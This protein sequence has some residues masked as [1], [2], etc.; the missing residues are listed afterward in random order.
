MITFAKGKDEF[1]ANTHSVR[2][3][4]FQHKKTGKISYRKI[5]IIDTRTHKW[6]WQQRALEKIRPLP[7]FIGLFLYAI[8]VGRRQGKTW[9]LVHLVFDLMFF[10]SES[11]PYVVGDYFCLTEKQAMRNAMEA[12]EHA[13]LSIPC[14]DFNANEGVVTIPYPKLNNPSNTLTFYLNG[15]RGG[16]HSKR[17]SKGDISVVDEADAYDKGFINKVVVVPAGQRNGLVFPV[18]TNFGMG[19]IKGYI[20]EAQRMNQLSKAIKEGKFHGT[21]PAS[22]H[23]YAWFDETAWKTGVFSK[24]HLNVYKEMMGEEDFAL[25]FENVDLNKMR[26][27]YYLS[28]MEEQGFEAKHHHPHVMPDPRLPVW[29]YYDLGIG[30]K[31]D[32]MVIILVQHVMGNM[33]VLWGHK[34]ENSTLE[35]PV[36]ALQKE[37]PFKEYEIKEHVLPH[38][39][40]KRDLSHMTAEDLLRKHLA[41]H[42]MAGAVRTREQS[43]S[44]KVAIEM[45]KVVLKNSVFNAPHASE[46]WEALR[47]HKR[48]EIAEGLYSD[49]AS[50]T[51]YRDIADA[52]ILAAVDHETGEYMDSVELREGRQQKSQQ[53][54]SAE[55]MTETPEVTHEGI[56]QM[57]TMGDGNSDC[58]KIGV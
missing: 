3:L 22:V 30:Q 40:K 10:F 52:F 6:E 43:E 41:K 23:N 21:P 24:E 4:F 48:R 54:Y 14:A 7:S 13:I 55:K 1:H 2:F 16:I 28:I 45:S 57:L 5:Y 31:R 51:K 33:V 53:Q 32:V 35:D 11:K 8:M 20:E 17:G 37:N 50:K 42:Q 56:S 58:F 47:N 36:I 9:T 18:G 12:I 19:I 34:I 46:V 38:D 27:F 49:D 39:G 44:K 29:V 26:Q 25:E 15:V